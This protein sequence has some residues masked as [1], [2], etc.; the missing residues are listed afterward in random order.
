MERVGA[1]MGYIIANIAYGDGQKSYP[2]NCFRDD[3][4]VGDQ[5]IVRGRADDLRVAKVVAL[6]FLNWDCSNTVLCRLSEALFNQGH[7]TVPPSVSW[8]RGLTRPE[9]LYEQ[10]VGRGWKRR[11]PR[12]KS[13]RMALSYEGSNATARLFFRMNGIDLQILRGET[14][15]YDSQDLHCSFSPGVGHVLRNS[16][17]K[18]GINILEHMNALTIAF[19][20][21][22]EDLSPF[23]TKHGRA[24]RTPDALRRGRSEES[25]ESMLYDALGGSGEDVY[26]GDGQWLSQSGRWSDDGR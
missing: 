25:F 22:V 15:S 8:V 5:V 20:N 7:I 19:Q 12:S 2:A 10:L 23:W 16:Y 1:R 6:D 4:A 17:H 13:Y 24:D 14:R 3:I 11:K 21:D 18:S 26:V 9:D